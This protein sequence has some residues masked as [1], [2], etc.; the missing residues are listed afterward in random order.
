MAAGFGSVSMSTL[1]VYLFT[2]TNL[3][4]FV[5]IP[6]VHRFILSPTGNITVGYV[7]VSYVLF[8]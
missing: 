3:I 7:A 8:P 4:S 2:L 1:Q 5:D 6:L